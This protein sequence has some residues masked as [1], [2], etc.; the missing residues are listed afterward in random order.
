M[1]E[2]EILNYINRFPKFIMV[3]GIKELRYG[4]LI[5]DNNILNVFEIIAILI[6]IGSIHFQYW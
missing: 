6:D 5:G 3:F 2:I 4:F 1:E